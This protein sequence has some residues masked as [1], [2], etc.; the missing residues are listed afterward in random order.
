VRDVL[1][2]FWRGTLGW[3]ALLAVGLLLVSALSGSIADALS[4]AP[5]WL[6]MALTLAAYP[7]GLVAAEPV[8]ADDR[9]SIPRA[10]VLLGAGLSAS[11]LAFIVTNFVAPALVDAPSG[12]VFG[13]THG[14]DLGALAA[15]LSAAREAAEGGP[16]TPEGWLPYN[17]LAF[18]YVRRTD[19]MLLPTLFSV[20]G[21]LSGY[22]TRSMDRRALRTLS[23]WG[24]G[25]FLL[26]AT[27]MAGENG[28]ELVVVR[29]AGP[30]EF[31]GDLALIVPGTLIVA[32]ALGVVADRWG[33]TR[34]R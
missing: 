15:A 30:V 21:L 19:G 23:T 16:A 10:C 6:V 34:V 11:F 29:A 2:T 25:G 18:H 3:T 12:D 5:V 22:W 14:M 26:V 9:A 28:Y 4:Q 20:V 13:A 24:L 7:G 17:H 1:T 27:Y 31:V 32:L 8:F 33:S